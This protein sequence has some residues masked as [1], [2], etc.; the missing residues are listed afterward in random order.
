MFGMIGFLVAL[1]VAFWVFS[2]ARGRGLTTG[3]AL[4]WFMGTLFLLIVFLPFWLIMRP[5]KGYAVATGRRLT[6]CARCGSSYEGM[7]SFCP[8][9][10]KQ[11]GG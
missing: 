7:A 6:L 11:I 5:G 9:C 8:T 2:D 10:V 3:K 4:L 1:A